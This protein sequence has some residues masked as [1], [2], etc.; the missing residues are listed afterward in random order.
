MEK[1]PAFISKLLLE[2]GLL[3]NVLPSIRLGLLIRN[4]DREAEAVFVQDPDGFIEVERGITRI[5]PVVPLTDRYRPSLS[6][7]VVRQN[8]RD[9]YRPEIIPQT[10]GDQI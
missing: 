8:D 1:V 7:R 4:K 3:P 10:L 2:D 9:S 5:F 6:H